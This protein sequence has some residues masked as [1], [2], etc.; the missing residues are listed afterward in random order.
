MKLKRRAGFRFLTGILGLFCLFLFVNPMLAG[1]LNIGNATGAAFSS[2]LTLGALFWKRLKSL[3]KAIWQRSWGKV[4]LAGF[5]GLLSLS[6]VSAMVLT[7]CM[8]RSARKT[9]PLDTTVVVLGCKVNGEAPSRMLKS[10][11]DCAAD[12][13]L[14]NPTARCVVSGGQGE[15][16]V[17]TE[18]Q[19]MFE[20]LMGKGISPERIYMEEQSTN[21]AET[22]Q[23]S[24]MIFE[25]EALGDTVVIVTDGFH[26]FR[27]ALLARQEGLKPYA[28]SAPTVWYLLP[29]YYVREL[30]ALMNQI[31]LV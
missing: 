28:V 6:L 22:I 1:V 30:F 17:V 3:C 11:L 23:F 10:R 2:F 20:Y 12:Y 4:L 14:E 7:A 27:A 18:A 13:L 16:E 25:K 24:H 9:P 8:V 26:Q 29:T 15:K 5:G 21:T 19:V 31:F